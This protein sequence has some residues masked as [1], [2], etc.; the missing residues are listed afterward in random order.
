MLAV[1]VALSATI[2]DASVLCRARS[3][4][5]CFRTKCHRSEHPLD[6]TQ[7]A[8]S[9]LA[10]TQGGPGTAGPIGTHPL[11]LVDSHGVELGPIM[12][13]FSNIDAFVA[14]TQPALGTTVLFEIAPQD[15][16]HNI[17]GAQSSAYYVTADCSGVPYLLFADPN[18]PFAQIFGTAAYVPTAVA[19]SVMYHSTEYDAEGS[20]C[21]G[22]ATDT[23]RGSC[24]SSAATGMAN[25]SPA[26]RV[27]LAALG[28]VPP[29]RAV[30]R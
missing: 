28:F 25:L 14:I 9:V 1:A 2:A 11:A 10:G 27:P 29:F 4:R 21:G 19:Q 20:P 5:V 30:P 24:C 26:A 7:L 13:M 3:G 8:L 18:E 16:V 23:G 6:A 22:G 17:G 15:Y 12:T